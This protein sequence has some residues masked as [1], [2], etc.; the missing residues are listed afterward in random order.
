MLLSLQCHRAKVSSA[1][2]SP[3]SQSWVPLDQGPI[4]PFCSSGPV[5]HLHHLQ[6]AC[7]LRPKCTAAL[8]S[9]LPTSIHMIPSCTLTSWCDSSISGKDG[10][11]R[12]IFNPKWTA[13]NLERKVI[14]LYNQTDPNDGLNLKTETLYWWRHLE[15]TWLSGH[16]YY[17]TLIPL[18]LENLWR[19]KEIR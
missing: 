17:F 18:L 5:M 7:V 8:T 13:K 2:E 9:P 15:D 1:H 11:S 10:M 19:W 3:S 14:F 4:A 12:Q 16:S 6:R